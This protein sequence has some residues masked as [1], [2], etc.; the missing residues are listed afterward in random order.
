MNS[1]SQTRLLSLASCPILSQSWCAK[2]KKQ[3]FRIWC[4]NNFHAFWRFYVCLILF[5]IV[6]WCFNGND[7]VQEAKT[8]QTHLITWISHR[9]YPS[10][11]PHSPLANYS[12]R[13]RFRSLI[14]LSS[15]W[16]VKIPNGLHSHPFGFAWSSG[17]NPFGFAWSSGTNP[18]GFAWSSGTNPYPFFH[19]AIFNPFSR[20]FRKTAGPGPQI[21]RLCAPGGLCQAHSSGA[22]GSTPDDS[23]VPG[24]LWGPPKRYPKLWLVSGHQIWF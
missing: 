17:T 11:K 18:F 6:W 22:G 14:V 21:L 12:R 16:L 20:F 7:M 10:S 24:Q 5:D 23:L 1:N 9:C 3:L 2:R 19:L 13:R 4:S 8:R 15:F